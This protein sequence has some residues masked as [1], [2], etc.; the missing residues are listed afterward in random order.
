MT[1]TT[2]ELARRWRVAP[3]KVLG[4]IR[5]GELVA[6]NLAAKPNGRPRYRIREADVTAFE[7][8]RTVMAT[9]QRKPRQK[10]SMR[11]V[12]EFL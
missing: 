4:L 11:D 8:S 12:I 9:P 6:I 7:M 1:I 2:K 10:R 3:A 5:C